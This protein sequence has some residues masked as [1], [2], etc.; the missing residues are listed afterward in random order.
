MGIVRETQVIV[1]KVFSKRNYAVARMNATLQM[2]YRVV[3]RE[4]PS[5][6]KICED[7]CVVTLAMHCLNCL[8]K[9]VQTLPASHECERKEAAYGME[10]EIMCTYGSSQ[11][12]CGS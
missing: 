8:V 9:F 1:T 2:Y 7:A 12:V 10:Q 5:C 6:G 3:T 4:R 11:A